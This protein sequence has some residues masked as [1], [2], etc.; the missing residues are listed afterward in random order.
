MDDGTTRTESLPLS[1]VEQ[2]LPADR[3]LRVHRSFTVNLDY[4]ESFAG[5]EVIIGDKHIPIGKQYRSSI[6]KHFTI[7]R[8]KR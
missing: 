5:N 4:V 3:F 8:A 1:A 2:Y 7:M 6:E